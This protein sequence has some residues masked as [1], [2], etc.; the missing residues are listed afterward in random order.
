MFSSGFCAKSDWDP[1][2]PTLI[3]VTGKASGVLTSTMIHQEPSNPSVN[4]TWKLVTED[5]G[6]YIKLL[7]INVT[8]P[9]N[10]IRDYVSLENVT[11]TDSKQAQCC[12]KG[13]G[14]HICRFSGK[15]VPPLSRSVSNF[16]I[17]NF[18]SESPANSYFKAIWYNVN[19]FF[20]NG[21]IP[22]Q[23]SNDIPLI[24]FATLKPMTV[25]PQYI[26]PVLALVLFTIIVFA[27]GFF[28]ACKVG[29][30]YL[31]PSCSFAYFC[32]WVSSLRTPQAPS[33]PRHREAPSEA[34]G[35]MTDTDSPFTGERVLLRVSDRSLSSHSGDEYN[36]SSHDSLENVVL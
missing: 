13:Q 27:V 33:T 32:A 26:P 36:A 30:R 9:T 21:L 18:Y 4:C 28:L 35:L 2:G 15:N 29:K 6:F 20:P 14:D 3:D 1:C 25:A 19:G 34:R 10:C 7:F 22:A 5:P 16:T 8:M 24:V 11:F 17:V 23:D 31:G 12:N